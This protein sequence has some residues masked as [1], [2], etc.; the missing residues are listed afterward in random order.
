MACSSN[1]TFEN[2]RS[3]LSC[4]VN[5]MVADGLAT[6]ESRESTDKELK[7]FSRILKFQ[8]QGVVSI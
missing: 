1:P 3:R 6:Q 7:Y 8:D 5:S 4:I 2:T